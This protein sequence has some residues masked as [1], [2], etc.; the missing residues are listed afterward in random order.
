MAGLPS[1]AGNANANATARKWMQMPPDSDSA[2]S[3]ESAATIK[4]LAKKYRQ[5]QTRIS[6]CGDET[7][8]MRSGSLGKF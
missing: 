7:E 8:R 1:G 4:R 6:C 2:L 3:D 5:R